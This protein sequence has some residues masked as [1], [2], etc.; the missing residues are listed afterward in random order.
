MIDEYLRSLA[1]EY[2]QICAVMN[3]GEYDGMQLTGLS[4]QRTW[5]HDELIRVLGAG[6][7]RPFDMKTHCRRLFDEEASYSDT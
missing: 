2:L 1:I 4:A 5:T 7:E 3:S 6:Y